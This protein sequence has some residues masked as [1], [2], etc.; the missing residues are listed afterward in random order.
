M[1]GL[2]TAIIAAASCAVAAR[3]AHK[4]AGVQGEAE[5]EGEMSGE[6][7][8]GEAP[9]EGVGMSETRGVGV[10]TLLTVGAVPQPDRSTIAAAA[11]TAAWIHLTLSLTATPAFGVAGAPAAGPPHLQPALPHRPYR[12]GI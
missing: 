2:P 11:E 3:A 5:G 1:A 10:P 12:M 9:A 7:G 8:G 4:L 6:A